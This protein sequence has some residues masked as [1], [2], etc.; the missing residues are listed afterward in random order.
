MKRLATLWMSAVLTLM[1]PTLGQA[2]SAYSC[3][4]LDSQQKTAAIEGSDGI[5]YR[6]EPDMRMFNPFSDETAD[7][8]AALSKALAALGTTLIYVPVPTKSLA[9]PGQLPQ[10]ARDY[11]FDVNIATTVYLESIKKLQKRSVLAVDARLALQAPLADGPSFFPTDYRM[12]SAG[13]AREAKAIAAVIAAAPGYAD[14]P[15]GRF[16]SSP[17]GKVA[18]DSAMRSVLQR[19]CLLPLPLAETD[20][21]S[22]NRV[23]GS[24]VA[25]DNTIFG[26]TGSSARVAIVGTEVDGDPVANL[27]GF[28]A[29][30]TG[31][32]TSAYAV[33]GG[34]GFAAIS[35]YLTSSAFQDARPAFLIW[36]NPINEN[37]ALYG[38]QPF[39]E[40]IAAAG[41][42][43]R[44]PL[45]VM[46]NL[47]NN[48]VVADLTPL[49]AGQSYT[50]FLDASGAPASQ[51]QF[52]FTA[53]NGLI[54]TKSIFRN[55]DQVKT[56]RFYMPMTSLWPE[57][58]QSVEI[59]LDVP[60]GNAP[61]VMACFN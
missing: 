8:M 1:C 49:D 58:A 33:T 17:A 34:G 54:R 3:T 31:L 27:A 41:D 6:V 10:L 39:A 48:S 43:C 52:D 22:S 59:T 56:G 61:R 18:V 28:V 16:D 53:S 45:P 35:S 4:G 30:A 21:Y 7:Q 44:V 5:F 50:L 57:G 20:T 37:L 14:L 23:Q 36:A 26:S 60:L 32:E 24:G 46:V 11:G 38:D 55:K 9:M 12:T 25:K 13:A 2:Q 42:N 51:A 29:K 19:H 47:Q 40:L 15:K